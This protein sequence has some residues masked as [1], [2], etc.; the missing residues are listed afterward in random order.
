[1]KLFVGI[2][3]GGVAAVASP[4]AAVWFEKAWIWMQI[5]APA[6]VHA[7]LGMIN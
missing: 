2:L 3:I 4:Y 1:M 7:V 5:H 6:M